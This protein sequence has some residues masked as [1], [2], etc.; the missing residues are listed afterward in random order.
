MANVLKWMR[1][2]KLTQALVFLGCFRD[3]RSIRGANVKK[4]SIVIHQIAPLLNGRAQDRAKN[5]CDAVYVLD[6]PALS[7]FFFI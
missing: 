7:C 2:Y 1:V 3:G 6:Y 5:R 4:W